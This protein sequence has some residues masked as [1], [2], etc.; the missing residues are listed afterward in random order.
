MFHE[1]T[2]TTRV[3]TSDSFC[4][5]QHKHAAFHSLVHRLCKIPL[6]VIQYKSEYEYIKKVANENGYPDSLVDR[7]IKKHTLKINRMNLTTLYHDSKK[8]KDKIRVSSYYN[9]NVTNNLNKVFNEFDMQCVYRSNNKLMN[10]LGS[11]K[12][13]KENAQK[14]G[15]YSISCDDCD[16][17][18]IGQTKRAIETRF[19]EHIS[20]IKKKDPNKSAFAAHIL[21]TEHSF[22][23]QQC[24]KLIKQV[25]DVR[26]LDAYESYYIQT[27]ENVMNLDNGNIESILFSRV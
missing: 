25:I 27:N 21:K 22:E 13:K 3:I 12:D 5:V 17:V 20:W 10:V 4:P 8:E 15:I 7:L 11:T 9:P 19:K 23:N 26:R 18:Y 14:S 6:S 24:A 16:S 2:S 1:E